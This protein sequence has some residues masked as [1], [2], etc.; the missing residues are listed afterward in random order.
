MM[1]LLFVLDWLL[2]VPKGTL[3][4]RDIPTWL[5]FPAIYV[6]WTFLHGAVSGFY[7][8][9]FVDV[10]A[11]G[12]ARVGLNVIGLFALFLLLGIAMTTLDH[13]LSRLPLRALPHT[14]NESD[15]RA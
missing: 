6:A 11:L 5:V 7:P 3:R 9:P 1:P 4:F 14:Q 2:F 12:Y 8:Y 10:G 15:P 13:L